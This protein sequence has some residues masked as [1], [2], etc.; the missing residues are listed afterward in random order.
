VHYHFTTHEAMEADI[1]AGKF[2]EYAH[3]HKNIYGTSIQAV[4]DVAT[5]G[6]CCVLDIDVQGARQVGTLVS[7]EVIELQGRRHRWC[8][9]MAWDTWPASAW[10]RCD[11]LAACCILAFGIRQA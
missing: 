9:V 2:L 6:R 11:V 3:V 1:A 10:A 8:L 7:I 5:A 4:R